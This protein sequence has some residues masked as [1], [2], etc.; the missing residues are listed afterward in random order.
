MR[1]RVGLPAQNRHR[2]LQTTFATVAGASLSDDKVAAIED[3]QQTRANASTAQAL[4][5]TK[6]APCSIA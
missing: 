1:G 2:Q 6:D 3:A 4:S 5:R